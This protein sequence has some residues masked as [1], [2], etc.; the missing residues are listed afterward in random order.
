MSEE[1]PCL[2]F[3]EKHKNSGNN[4]VPTLQQEPDALGWERFTASSHSPGVVQSDEFVLRL[5]FQPLHIDPE[6]RSLKPSAVSDVKD[7]GFSVDRLKYVSREASVE[8]GRTQ[9]VEAVA[10]HGRTPRELRAI[11][12]LEVAV[13]RSLLVNELRAFGVYDTARDDNMAHADV[14]QLVPEGQAGRSARSRL[15]E[16]CDSC[17]EILPN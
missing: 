8:S 14:C 17:L 13:V 11:S 16:L 12:T 4:K 5:A 7:K 3:F 1:N 6:T 10:L 9:A 2:A 15:L